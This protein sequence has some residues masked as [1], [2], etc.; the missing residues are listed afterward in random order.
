MRPWCGCVLLIWGVCF[1]FETFGQCMHDRLEGVTKIPIL[2]SLV[3]TQKQLE[4]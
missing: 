4:T 1:S 3:F 2:L